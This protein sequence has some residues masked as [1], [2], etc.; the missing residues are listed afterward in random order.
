MEAGSPKPELAA[1]TNCLFFKKRS[2]VCEKS[3][4]HGRGLSHLGPVH[5][6]SSPGPGGEEAW[7]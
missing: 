7:L 1:G 6:L 3:S 4:G 2:Y 5:D